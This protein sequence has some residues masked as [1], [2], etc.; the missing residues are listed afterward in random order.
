MGKSVFPVADYEARLGVLSPD[1]PRELRE[2]VGGIAG[3][4]SEEGLRLWAEEGVALAGQ[5]VRSWEAA[6]EYF[7]ASPRVAR[8]LPLDCLLRWA[9]LGRDMAEQSSVVAAAYFRAGPESLGLLTPPEMEQW[10]AAGQ[11]LYQG[12][13][14]SISLASL[15]FSVSPTLLPL[16]GVAD[17]FRLQALAEGLAERSYE[18]AGNCLE[19]A[20]DVFSRIEREDRAPFLDL[21][22]AIA[23]AGWA[24]VRFYFERGP[25]LLAPVETAQRGRF[26]RLAT[27]VARRAGQHSFSLFAESAVALAQVSG[28]SHGDLISLAEE[29]AVG[30]PAAAMEFLKSAPEVLSRISL[31]DLAR[32]HAGGH[33]I[34]K[35][36]SEGGEAYFR[37]QSG[38]SERLLEALSPRVELS[39][40][41]EVLRLYCKA[42]SGI[43]VSIHPSSSLTEKGIGW[44]AS[45]R[46]S[47]EG[48]AV[49]LPEFAE[50]FPDKQGNFAVYKIYAT[51]QAGH[52]EF[53]SFLFDFGSR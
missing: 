23:E 46:P 32:W 34:L 16:L 1:L 53:G 35:E 39:R 36:S 5:S 22:Q 27:A 37:L 38:K 41:G 11:R 52:L 45:E 15:F 47:T 9:H 2:A 33:R 43:N 21:A 29:L 6:S 10:A 20:P 3:Q 50:E 30:S 31:P 42:L 19:T 7:R 12:N 13:W 28:D 14:K 48:T 25:G 49:Y 26:L 8:L 40:V 24:D 18:L 4:L 17:L 51:H 44:V